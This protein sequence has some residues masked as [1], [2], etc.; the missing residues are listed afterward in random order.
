MGGAPRRLAIAEGTHSV[1][2]MSALGARS[3]MFVPCAIT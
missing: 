1:R 2:Y 3:K